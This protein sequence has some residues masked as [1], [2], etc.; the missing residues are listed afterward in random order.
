MWTSEWQKFGQENPKDCVN[1]NVTNFDEKH[2]FPYQRQNNNG[3][4]KSGQGQPWF[5]VL[6]WP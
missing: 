5:T 2:T 4:I 1:R 3:K 6:S